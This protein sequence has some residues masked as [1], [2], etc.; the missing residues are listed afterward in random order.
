MSNSSKKITLLFSAIALIGVVIYFYFKD[1]IPKYNWSENY[2]NTNEQPYGL[3]LIFNLLSKT[4]SKTD[5]IIINKPPKEAL[6]K[7]DSSSLYILI[8]GNFFIDSLSSIALIDFV[9]RG[10]NAFISSIEST[11]LLFRVLTNAERPTLYYTNFEDSV[12]D[13]KFDS[14]HNNA[15]Y[16][17]E[18]KFYK[19]LAK[20]KWA[21]VDSIMFADTLS[22]YRYERVTTIHNYYVDCFRVK[23]GKGWFIFHFNPLFLTNYNLSGKD[24]FNYV[25][26]LFSDYNKKTIYWDEFSKTATR[27]DYQNPGHE[28]PLRFIL[29][30]RSLKWAWYLICILVS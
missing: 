7:S 1:Y 15:S 9:K 22:K 13:V 29:S 11:H 6:N 30:Q 28:S 26:S 5:F 19:K 27:D 3:K 16:K 14:I 21:G 25:N 10:N 18:Y 8:G 17:F 24:G 12:I 2:I 4:H 23:C 20:Y